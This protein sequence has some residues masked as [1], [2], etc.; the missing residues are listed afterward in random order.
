MHFLFLIFM[1]P[2]TL[3]ALCPHILVA[4]FPCFLVSLYPNIFILVSLYLC[5][6]VLLYPFTFVPLYSYHCIL[7]CILVLWHSCTYVYFNPCIVVPSRCIPINLYLVSLYLNLALLECVL[8]VNEKQTL[9]Y[10][11]QIKGMKVVKNDKQQSLIS[12]WLLIFKNKVS[13]Y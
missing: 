11:S 5:I 7:A 8:H 3:E 1:Y 6:L 10:T 12:N 4:L 9:S 2:C 13:I